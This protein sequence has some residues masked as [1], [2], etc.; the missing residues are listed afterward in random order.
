MSFAHMYFWFDDL[1]F[2]NLVAVGGKKEI[3]YVKVKMNL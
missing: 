2:Q 3:L 1:A